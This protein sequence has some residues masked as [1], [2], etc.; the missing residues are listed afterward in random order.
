M[1][2]A[3]RERR[4]NVDLPLI[5]FCEGITQECSGG[6]Q[7]HAVVPGFRGISVLSTLFGPDMNRVL[8]EV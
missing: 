3:F 5:H 7:C 2:P 8:T 6:A 1:G 4:V